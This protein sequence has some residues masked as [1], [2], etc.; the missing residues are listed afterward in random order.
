MRYCGLVVAA[1][2]QAS[3]AVLLFDFN[4]VDLDWS[5]WASQIADHRL[6]AKKSTCCCLVDQFAGSLLCVKLR[7]ATSRQDVWVLDGHRTAAS[8]V[9]HSTIRWRIVIRGP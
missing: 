2:S 6:V 9:G 5:L 3:C 8:Q 7:H 4:D 1:G